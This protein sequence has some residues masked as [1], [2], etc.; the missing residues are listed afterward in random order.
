[1]RPTAEFALFLGVGL[2]LT[3]VGAYGTIHEPVLERLAFWLVNLL[4]GG[5]LGITLDRHLRRRIRSDWARA[6]VTAAAM[7]PPIALIVLGSMVGVLHH[8]HADTRAILL[9]LGWQVFLVSLVVMLLR[10]LVRRRP[11]RVVEKQTVIMPQVPQAEARFRTHL[12]A[13]RRGSA[14][15]AIEAHDHYVRVHTE[16]GTELVALRF[17]DAL[18]E[19]ADVAGFQVHRSWWIA[20]SAIQSARWQ[21]SSGTI[22]LKNGT[23]APVSR[24]GAPL[25]RAAG[26]L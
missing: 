18:D 25:L 21:R 11:A 2:F 23:T 8:D 26:W 1:M 12:S 10:A 6:A 16:D 4:A 24:S 14:L 22:L 20:A 5:I 3:A 13:R 9:T 7:T 17:A 15:L 19:L